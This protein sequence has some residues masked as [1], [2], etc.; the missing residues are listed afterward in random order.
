MFGQMSSLCDSVMLS[1]S[2]YQCILC[3]RSVSTSAFYFTI[4]Y[5]S[6]FYIYPRESMIFPPKTQMRS[7][8]SQSALSGL[9]PNQYSPNIT[10]PLLLESIPHLL[11]TATKSSNILLT[12]S[13]YS[14]HR[15]ITLFIFS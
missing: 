11:P 2:D 15:V 8:L 1:P 6:R 3:D 5:E 7:R 9:I 13:S 12:M 14:D 4:I 10:F